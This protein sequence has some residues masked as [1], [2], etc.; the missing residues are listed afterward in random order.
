MK[1]SQLF[2]CFGVGLVLVV[3]FAGCSNTQ[4]PAEKSVGMANPAAV[5]CEQHGSYELDTGQCN[6]KLGGSVDAWEFYR[7]HHEEMPN[8]A[9]RYCESTNGV[10][11]NDSDECELPDGKV[12]D[13]S[14]YFNAHKMSGG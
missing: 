14:E 4:V 11:K 3:S 1:N 7:L 2:M 6:L 10:Y 9:A 5:Y 12:M 8:E 13:A